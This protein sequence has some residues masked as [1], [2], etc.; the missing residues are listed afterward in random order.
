MMNSA[1][2]AG[3]AP[4]RVAAAARAF[5]G[6]D[7]DAARRPQ[8]LLATIHLAGQRVA[9]AAHQ[10]RVVG[11]VGDHGGHVWRSR[12]V[13]KGCP[14]LE[15]DEQ[16]VERQRGLRTIMPSAIVRN[17][18]DFPDPVAPMQS[19]CGPIPPSAGSLMSSSRRCALHGG[20]DGDA[21]AVAAR[22]AAP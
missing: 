19:P 21:Q 20:A 10:R 8:Q 2:R 12:I 17:S 4:R 22:L 9:H 16:Q 1:G 14:A 15:V 13:E 3:S 18:S 6:L 11:Q 5:V 7:A